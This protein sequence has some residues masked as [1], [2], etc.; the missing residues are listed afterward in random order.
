MA[1][2]T[3]SAF[4]ARWQQITTIWQ[5]YLLEYRILVIV[6]LIVAGLWVFGQN[7]F[8]MVGDMLGYVMNIFTESL[9]IIVT[10]LVLDR[11]NARRQVEHY[12]AALKE[13]LVRRAGSIVND[14]AVD[15]VEQLS[16]ERLLESEGGLLVGANLY[17][18]N[19]QEAFL[20]YANLQRTD[21][22]LA[23][24]Q[25][26]NLHMANLQHANLEFANLQEAD[27]WLAKLQ[28]ALLM[29]ASLQHANME[30]ANLQE[31]ILREANLQNVNLRRANLQGCELEFANLQ[32][33]SLSS[34][35]LQGAYLGCADLRGA[36]L[37]YA[38]LQGSDLGQANLRDAKNIESAR[39]DEKTLLPDAEFQRDENGNLIRDD[40]G[41]RLFIYTPQS[42]WT[43]D[44][45]MTRYTN[46]HHPDFWIPKWVAA[47]FSA[48]EWYK[49]N[50]EVRPMRGNPG[51]SFPWH[52]AGYG[53]DHMAWVR[54]GNQDYL[55]QYIVAGFTSHKDWLDAGYNH[56]AFDSKPHPWREA[57][58]GNDHMAWMRDGKPD[59]LTEGEPYYEDRYEW[60]AAGYTSKHEWYEADIPQ[61]WREAGYGKDGFMAWVRDGKPEPLPLDHP[62]SWREEWEIAGYESFDE[63]RNAGT[64]QPWRNAGYDDDYMAWVRD[65]K[66]DKKPK[67]K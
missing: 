38:G 30:S 2:N 25:R 24:L 61:P 42:Y 4:D 33:A 27:L 16:K 1:K 59:A 21:L 46:P 60:L 48:P 41:K 44:T 31:A 5:T 3:Q 64:P 56:W 20:I 18:A 7:G 53:N 6:A 28:H 67:E 19:L 8:N 40:K 43:P 50:R 22:R 29:Y 65:G 62:K 39:F 14:F 32:G 49:T 13:N 55:P 12:N 57:G 37:E 17:K 66:P 9:S 47:G 35:K 10:V 52:D 63:H 51:V 26:A 11:L 34:G 58:Y 45:D 54:D 15:A 36:N 23:N